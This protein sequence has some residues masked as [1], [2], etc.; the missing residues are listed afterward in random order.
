[1]AL[2]D[3][4]DGTVNE[5]NMKGKGM[6]RREFRYAMALFTVKKK[7]YPMKIKSIIVQTYTEMNLIGLECH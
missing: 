5:V 7:N 3:A 4:T 2:R 1:M 6:T